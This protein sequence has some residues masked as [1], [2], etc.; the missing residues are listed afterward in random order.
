MKATHWGPELVLKVG[1]TSRLSSKTASTPLQ[2]HDRRRARRMLSAQPVPPGPA[3][4]FARSPD[5]AA[6]KMI[7]S[8]PWAGWSA[9]GV[10]APADVEHGPLKST[11][12]SLGADYFLQ[13]SRTRRH[14]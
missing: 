4:L 9:R 3:A 12:P 8:S 5:V 10:L 2:S 14:H 1:G 6:C 7:A 13:G 11:Y